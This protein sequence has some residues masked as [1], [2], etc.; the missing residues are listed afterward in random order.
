ML[1]V[2]TSRS[3]IANRQSQTP[4]ELTLNVE[5]PLGVIALLRIEFYQRGSERIEFNKRND[6]IRKGSCRNRGQSGRLIVRC[7]TR[8]PQDEL[9]REGYDIIQSE[10]GPDRC[11]AVLEGVPSEAD[12]RCKVLF[13][14]VVEVR[15]AGRRQGVSNL[16]QICKLAIYFVRNSTDFIAHTQIDREVGT[17]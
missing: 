8:D 2:H 7:G 4:G 9:I 13:S 10:S 5:I 15:I 12:P 16:A 17:D 3:D 1:Q 11:L 6:V 14:G